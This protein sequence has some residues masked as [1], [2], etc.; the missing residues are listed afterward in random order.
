MA[1]SATAPSC[2]CQPVDAPLTEPPDSAATASQTF[3]VHAHATEESLVSAKAGTALPL[4]DA[5][6]LPVPVQ[7]AQTSCVDPTATASVAVQE[8]SVPWA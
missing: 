5:G 8:T 6:T 4:P 3:V 7:P 1:V 2:A